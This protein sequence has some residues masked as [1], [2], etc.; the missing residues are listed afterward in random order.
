MRK[1]AGAHLIERDHELERLEPDVV[2]SV[3]LLQQ[4]RRQGPSRRVRREKRADRP[5]LTVHDH[6]E[7][8]HLAL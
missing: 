6:V 8:V 2:E 7:D 3:R 4:H 5:I 1:T